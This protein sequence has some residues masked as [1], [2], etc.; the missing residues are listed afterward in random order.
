MPDDITTIVNQQRL[1]IKVIS[2]A[3]NTDSLA[4]Y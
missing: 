2:V 1:G 4:D 3:L